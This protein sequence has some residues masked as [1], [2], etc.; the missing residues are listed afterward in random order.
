M[1]MIIHVFY[2]LSYIFSSHNFLNSNHTFICLFTYTCCNITSHGI[3]ILTLMNNIPLFLVRFNMPY[4]ELPFF[5][6]YFSYVIFLAVC[7]FLRGTV[8]CDLDQMI[9][10]HTCRLIVWQSILVRIP[11]F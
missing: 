3:N 8:N 7:I 5:F 1:R 6:F 4:D 10:K 2:I 9:N 11:L